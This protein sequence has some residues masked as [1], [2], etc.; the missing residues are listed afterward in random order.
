MT[1]RISFCALLLLIFVMGCVRNVPADLPKLYPLTVTVIQ[2]DKPLDEATVQL[3]SK[4]EGSRW[5]ACGV[6]DSSGNVTFFTQGK[7][8]GVPAG[9]YLAV[10]TKTF[11]EP[12]QYAGKQQP[13]DVDYQ[14][15]QRRLGAERLKSYNVIDYRYGAKETTPLE[16]IAGP[17]A[18]KQQQV[19][20]GKSIREEI[21]PPV[22]SIVAR[23]NLSPLTL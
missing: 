12:S 20:I 13:V 15:W 21:K 18:P 16:V 5:S 17:D 8:Q 9:M 7:Y 6:T 4:D 1:F 19:N 23:P 2:D 14:E 3:I 22:M 10:V 11:T